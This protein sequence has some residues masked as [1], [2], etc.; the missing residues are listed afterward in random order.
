MKVNELRKGKWYLYDAG[1]DPVKI[2][3]V[4]ETINGY[5]FIGE[6]GIEGELHRT[7]VEEIE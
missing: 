5:V 2:K 6:S 7:S 1:M 4:K 3:F